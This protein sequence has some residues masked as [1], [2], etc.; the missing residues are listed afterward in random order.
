M[1]SAKTVS[2]GRLINYARYALHNFSNIYEVNKRDRQDRFSVYR[3]EQIALDT[4]V[5]KLCRGRKN[6]YIAWGEV[7]TFINSAGVRRA[8]KGKSCP[9]KKFL[10]GVIRHRLVDD[11]ILVNEFCTSKV[12]LCAV[13]KN[14]SNMRREGGGSRIHTIKKCETCGMIWNRDVIGAINI[15]INFYCERRGEPSPFQVL[16][17]PNNQGTGR[18]Q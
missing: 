3:Q 14:L 16:R 18:L 13:Q 1:P 12:C 5:K 9:S 17:G 10:E 2:G 4:L 6:T 11:V 8:M 15:G 7:A